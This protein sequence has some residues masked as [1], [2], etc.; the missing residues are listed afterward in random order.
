MEKAQISGWQFYLLTFIQL[1]GTTFFLRPQG[2]IAVAKQDAWMIWFWAGGA[3]MILA[4]LWVK[5]AEQYPGLSFVQ[6][7]LGAGGKWVGGGIAFCYIGF[8]VQ[9][10]AWVVRNLGDFMKSTFMHRTPISVFHIMILIVV[11]YASIKGVEAIARS[12]EILTPIIMMTFFVVCIFMLP[13]WETERLLPAFRLELWKTV[14]ETRNIVGFPYI[15]SIVLMMMF[16]Y[17]RNRQKA[18]FVWAIIG[19]TLLLSGITVFLVA[20]LGVTRASHE[21]YPLFILVQDIR[22]GPLIENLEASITVILLVAIFLKITIT[23]HGAVC[24]IC[25]LFR[26]TDRTWVAVPLAVIVAGLAL[27][28]ENVVENVE[29]DRRYLFEYELLYGLIF[30]LILLAVTWIRKRSGKGQAS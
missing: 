28:N 24:G 23:F 21:T 8:F 30:P 14:K 15:E 25:Q 27:S 20:C 3:G 2:I 6:I 11:C 18:G 22:I 9:L 12:S 17:V 5:L 16:P 7:C 29:W 26:L 4:L 13:I 10:A 1:L 19:S